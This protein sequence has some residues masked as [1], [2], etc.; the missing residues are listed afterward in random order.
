MENLSRCLTIASPSAFAKAASV[1]GLNRRNRPLPVSAG[2]ISMILD[3]DG[4]CQQRNECHLARLP[5]RRIPVIRRGT[6]P[7]TR[8][9]WSKGEQWTRRRRSMPRCRRSNGPSARARS[10]GS[11]RAASRSRSRPFRPARSASTS[12]S[13]SAACRAAGWSKSTGRNP[14]ARRRW[15]CIASPRRRSA[16]ASAPSSMPSMRSIRSMRASSAS[17]STTS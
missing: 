7:R 8:C 1:G 2:R 6:W 13:A 3:V 17:T 4:R 5:V 15:R 10:C 11:A 14:R 16:A 9:E 12:R